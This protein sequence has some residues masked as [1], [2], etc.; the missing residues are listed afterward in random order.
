MSNEKSRDSNSSSRCHNRF[1]GRED[2]IKCIMQAA[3]AK[4]ASILV[5]YG[6]RRVGKTELIEHTLS[7]RNVLKLEGVEDGDTKSQMYRVLYQLSQ[8]FND[9]YIA[10]MQFDTWLELFDFIAS[11][12]SQGQWTL[13]LEELQWLADYKNELIADLKYVWDNSLRYNSNLLLVLCGSSP[14]FMRNQVVHS[15]ALY[16]RSLYEIHLTEFSL[17]ETQE[18]LGKRSQREI[19]DA[20]LTIGGIP[21]YLKRMKKHS[22]IQIGI[23]DESF[24]KDSYFSN[25]KKRI[26]I[27]SFASN[28]HYEEI[29]DF[30]S[31]VKFASKIDIE[32]HLHVKGGGN[33][34]NVLNDLEQCGFI[35]RYVP[36]QVGNKSNLVRYC[37][38]DNYLRFYFKFIAPLSERIQQADFNRMPFHALNKESYQKWLGFSFERFCRKNSQLIATIIGFSAVRYKSGAFFNRSSLK[39]QPGYQIDLIFDRADHVLTICEIKYT[40]GKTETEVIDEF[41]QKLRLLPDLTGKTIEKVLISASGASEGLLAQGYFD[42]VITLDDIFKSARFLNESG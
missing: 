23:C 1:V 8:A 14:S 25:E 42:R 38:A 7:K 9:A 3:Q 39:D 21:E 5:V 35:E 27:S 24:K 32:K 19:M 6:R 30:L 36:Y 10:R 33:L 41:E 13:Y 40:I 11:K 34:T 28:V 12:I 26:F 16:N 20:Y 37:I 29:I 22:S 31:Q 2:E 15:K 4:E 18:F 17:K